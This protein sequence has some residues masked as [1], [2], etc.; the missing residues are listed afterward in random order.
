MFVLKDSVAELK[1]NLLYK[2]NTLK[3]LGEVNCAFKLTDDLSGP[4]PAA[5]LK[6][7]VT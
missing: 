4:Y 3:H 7:S 6:R 5:A 1:N 2:I